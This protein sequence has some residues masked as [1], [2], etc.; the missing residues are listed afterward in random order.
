MRNESSR[1]VGPTMTRGPGR[2]ARAA[3]AA[4][5]GLAVAAPA[6]AQTAVFQPTSGTATWNAAS[7][8]CPGA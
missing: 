7:E 8:W 5:L 6:A 1:R 2:A 3:L 4:G